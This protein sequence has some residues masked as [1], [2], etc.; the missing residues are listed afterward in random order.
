MAPRF[1]LAVF[2]LVIALGSTTL[3]QTPTPKAKSAMEYYNSL[4][5]EE[6][7]TIIRKQASV[8]LFIAG[9][10]YCD[11]IEDPKS[12]WFY[13]DNFE[14]VDQ[15]CLETII[16]TFQGFPAPEDRL[17]GAALLYRY[18]EP[19]GRTYLLQELPKG[20]D[21]SVA[22]IF[23]LNHEDEALA[24]V[25]RFFEKDTRK[26]PDLIAALGSWQRPTATRAL[27][28]AYR[29]SLG[30]PA[31][32]EALG[33]AGVRE[34]VPLMEESFALVPRDATDQVVNLVSAG[35]LARLDVRRDENVRYLVEQWNIEHPSFAAWKVHVIQALGLAGGAQ[36]TQ[37]LF[38]A[39]DRY[40]ALRVAGSESTSGTEEQ[41]AA[42]AAA[43]ALSELKPPGT[44]DHLAALLAALTAFHKGPPERTAIALLA[45]GSD[46]ATAVVRKEMGEVWLH[47]A[48]AVRGL[49]PLP[50]FL[51]PAASRVF[52]VG[53]GP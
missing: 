29:Q 40:V 25:I 22:L 47:R 12:M 26:R 24:G 52:A 34:A 18:G 51:L 37:P 14:P 27:L 16:R 7:V 38:E 30:N 21:G 39:I 35:A 45:L 4:P 13:F 36:V 3:G 42:L 17:R 43:D 23:A 20:N 53:T 9:V 11:Y 10:P 1:E 48:Q 46:D 8:G 50:S 5:L 2:L 6:R 15:R 49:K 28:Q 32:A 33:R 19:L 31:Y 41:R 44:I